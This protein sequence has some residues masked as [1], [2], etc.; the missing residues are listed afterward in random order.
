MK[1]L[2]HILILSLF[3]IS[4]TDNK[5]SDISCTFDGQN[6]TI[7]NASSTIRV[8]NEFN[9][10]IYFEKNKKRYP[11][12]EKNKPIPSIFLNDSLNNVISF[13][14]TLPK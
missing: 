5:N 3:A 7:R 10:E 2:L 12:T 1:S 8:D 4:C 9:F 11:L 13:K 14:G 6:I